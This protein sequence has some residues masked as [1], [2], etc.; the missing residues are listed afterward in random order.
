MIEQEDP[1]CTGVQDQPRQNP[2]LVKQKQSFRVCLPCFTVQHQGRKL[3][4]IPYQHES[5]RK[6]KWPQANWLTNL[7][8]FIHNTK[9]KS[10]SGKYWMIYSHT[11]CCNYK[12]KK[13]KRKQKH[14]LNVQKCSLF[15][16][17]F[18]LQDQKTFFSQHQIS[19]DII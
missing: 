4:M 10:F 13:K 6:K 15:F 17:I 16:P 2:S 1:L 8:G 12:L 7:G 19:S 18:Q 5:P 9:I 14:Q 3:L 11:C